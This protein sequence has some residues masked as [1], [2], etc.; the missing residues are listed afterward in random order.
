MNSRLSNLTKKMSST[1]KNLAGCGCSQPEPITP[2]AVSIAPPGSHIVAAPCADAC[3]DS[4][5]VPGQ[6]EAPASATNCERF[7]NPSVLA[8]F[9]TPDTGKQGQF[10]A[11]CASSWALPGLELF[12]PGFGK[13][14]IISV[15]A[16]VVT[17]ENLTIER[18]TQILEGTLFHHDAPPTANSVTEG[19]AGEA[20][21]TLSAVYGEDNGARKVIAPVDGTGIFACGGKW[22][23][24][25]V[26]Q[27]RY[28]VGVSLIHST[29]RI[30]FAD[31]SI[32]VSLPGFPDGWD[33]GLGIGV[34]LT[35]EVQA[36]KQNDTNF[37]NVGM[38]L[39]GVHVAHASAG[40]KR[41][42]INT[43]TII[44]PAT[45]STLSIVLTKRNS[46][47]GDME[48]NVWI[49]AYHY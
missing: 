7:D 39:N 24:R 37:P 26:G 34:E 13:I 4:S 23:R 3:G 20:S 31:K 44:V 45:T 33:C 11:L 16:D 1:L 35:G 25:Q 42:K 9:V 30:T 22:Q 5:S 32:S 10:S 2:G 19:E 40:Y 28:P 41:G 14:K 18:G 36:W 38:S 6:T 12:F 15:S 46:D 17:Y 8:N 29:G 48:G 27:M 49:H 43:N 21:T 47:S